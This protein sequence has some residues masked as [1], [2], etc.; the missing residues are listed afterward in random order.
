MS[1]Q[2]TGPTFTPKR[3]RIRRSLW[4][5]LVVVLSLLIAGLSFCLSR[6]RRQRQ[7]LPQPP[8]VAQPAGPQSHQPWLANLSDKVTMELVW[9]EPGEFVMGT[10]GLPSYS[11]D[12]ESE[13]PH[14]VRLTQGWWMGRCEVTQRQYKTL[15]GANPSRFT[16]SGADA[17]VEQVSW[18]DS[19][20]FCRRLTAREKSAG[21]LPPRFEYRLPTEAQWEYACRAGTTGDYAGPLDQQAWYD[22]TSGGTTHVG[23]LKEPNAWGLHDMQ[24]NVCEWCADWYDDKSGAA[25]VIDP[26]GPVSGRYRVVRGG[27]W[28]YPANMCRSG[29]R[30]G[31]DPSG[32]SGRRF[33][34]MG[35]RIVLVSVP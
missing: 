35:F 12:L 17:P 2:K 16:R 27:G 28:A 20:E 21:C 14:R 10:P 26:V 1:H 31:I 5:M 9:I 6:C 23:G 33:S 11:Q 7:A 30:H 22:K 19:V 13:R 8:T 15:M 4:V 18:Q 24:G 29:F 3:T 34:S 25:D 32:S